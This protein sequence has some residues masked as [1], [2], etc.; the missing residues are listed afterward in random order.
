[1]ITYLA[2][3]VVLAV[4]LLAIMLRRIYYFF[5]ARELKRQARSGDHEATVLY[6][7]VSYGSSLRLLLWFIIGVSLAGGYILLTILAPSWLVFLAVAGLVWYGFAWSPNAQVTGFGAR[8]ALLVTPFVARVLSISHPL[9]DR[10]ASSIE[11]HRPVVFHTGLFERADLVDLIKDQRQLTDSRIPHAEL[12]LVLHALSFGDK[13]VSDAMVPRGEVKTVNDSDV[14]GPILMDELYESKHSRF[15]VVE[16]ESR[17]IVGTLYLRDLV[18]AR[19][20]G[21]LRAVMDTRI[22]YVHEDQSLYQVLHAFLT[23]KQ[24]LFYVI[25]SAEECIGVITIDDVLEQVIGHKIEDGFDSYDDRRAVATFMPVIQAK[26]H[27]HPAAN[28]DVKV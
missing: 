2:A 26:G 4:A 11:R 14:I 8:L 21:T 24:H 19:H 28:D 27:M 12:D 22:N 5:P 6:R 25:N 23:T 20:G 15:P 17:A 16:T 13:T 7:A 1:M 10:L 18:A 9:L 3:L